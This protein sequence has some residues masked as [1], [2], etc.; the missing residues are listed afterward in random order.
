VGILKNAGNTLFS[1][2]KCNS[3]FAAVAL[4]STAFDQF[5]CQNNQLGMARLSGMYGAPLR[6]GSQCDFAISLDFS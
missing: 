1:R 3:T 6:G 5:Y 4:K 2:L